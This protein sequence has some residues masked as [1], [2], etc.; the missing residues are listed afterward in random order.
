MTKIITYSLKNAHKNSEQFYRNLGEFTD[1][2]LSEAE[3]Q[4]A[5]I[6]DV[7]LIWV[8]AHQE[9]ELRSR[10]EYIFDLL[11]LGVL[12]EEHGQKVAGSSGRF[13]H[14]LAR[15]V[16]L[17]KKVPLLKSGIDA[18]R[19]LLG[20]LSIHST[21]SSG[22]SAFLSE[23]NLDR[24]LDWLAASGDF[25]EEVRRL[26][27]WGRFFAGQGDAGEFLQQVTAFASWFEAASLDALGAY[28]PNVEA[29]LAHNHPAHRWQED[30]IFTGRG[31]VEY[32]L[33]MIGMEIMNRSFRAQFL[34]AEQKIIFVPP[35]MAAPQDGSCQAKDTPYGA[36]CAHCTPSCQV[37]QIT[38]YGEK[39]GIQVFMI[40]DSFSP[41]SDGDGA[42]A[43][44][45][46]VLGV[47]CP[48]TITGGGFEMR[49]VGIPAQGVLLDHC[50]CHW[51]WDPGKGI[52][53]EINFRQLTRILEDEG[54]PR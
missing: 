6:L 4:L 18:L 42:V 29:Y 16:T 36:V 43:K 2:V 44:S 3:A 28:T 32:H 19:G 9:E 48:V 38:K 24:L 49:R 54:E 5:H 45:L 53:T 17:R 11:V 23:V 41:L 12:W 7:F 33:Y 37:N 51:H 27:L 20:G 21:V 40:P 34:A 22:R 52:V 50:G 47:S 8:E 25:K 31:R 39:F 13:Q 30:F 35:C 26:R 15:L 14:T 1:Q 10:P 46:G